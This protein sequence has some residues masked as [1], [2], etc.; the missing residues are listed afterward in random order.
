MDTALLIIVTFA[1]IG[2]SFGLGILFTDK[3][4]LKQDQIN[5]GSSIAKLALKIFSNIAKDRGFG[6]PTE[7]DI[8]VNVSVDAIDYI[9]DSIYD[10]K[11][12]LYERTYHLIVDNY[13]D[14]TGQD[15]TEEQVDIVEEI[16]KYGVDLVR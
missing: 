10:N 7:I 6:T 5:Q 1:I 3:L 2:V 12:E 14:I 4:K 13:K 16:I 9:K 8:I 15:L 11:D